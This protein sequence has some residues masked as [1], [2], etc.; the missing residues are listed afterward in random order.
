MNAL[1]FL[2]LESDT[3]KLPW[4]SCPGDWFVCLCPEQNE[5]VYVEHP[6][7]IAVMKSKG[8]AVIADPEPLGPDI[9]GWARNFTENYRDYAVALGG[10]VARYLHKAKPKR[11]PGWVQPFNLPEVSFEMLF[12][13][14]S[15]KTFVF[16]PKNEIQ[17]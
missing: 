7:V 3:K 6:L 8:E 5:T 10:A 9:P 17:M 4:R 14:W 15:G 11:P 1:G 12:G 16:L 2:L 13:F